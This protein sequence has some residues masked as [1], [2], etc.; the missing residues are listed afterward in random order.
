MS[1]RKTLALTALALFLATCS[2]N[3]PR[4][5]ITLE[6]EQPDT[7][8][9]LPAASHNSQLKLPIG[10]HWNTWQCREGTFDTRYPD[11]SKRTL[12]L[13]YMSGEHPLEQRP[14]DNPA[15]YENGQIAFQYA[16]PSDL[17]PSMKP[18]HNPN[19]SLHAIAR[20]QLQHGAG[21]VNR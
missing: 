11:S 17:M 5:D 12:Q 6:S 18:Q 16:S 3:K 1:T 8:I 15:T 2:S 13:R 10:N 21:K 20:Q 14:G 4:P 19:G 7:D 9:A